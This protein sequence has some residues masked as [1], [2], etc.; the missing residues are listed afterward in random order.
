MPLQKNSI[1]FFAVLINLIQVLTLKG[2]IRKRKSTIVNV[3]CAAQ[4][5]T[6]G[7]FRPNLKI[8]LW[9]LLFSSLG[10]TQKRLF[11]TL[12]LETILYYQL[13]ADLMKIDYRSTIGPIQ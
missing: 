2:L 9:I 3:P 13:E 1:K 12:V 10:K 5:A 6:I 7:H 11:V 4:L 8:K